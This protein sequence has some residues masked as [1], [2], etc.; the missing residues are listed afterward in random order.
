MSKARRLK[1][2]RKQE[3]TLA[4]FRASLLG[5]GDKLTD[6]LV[7]MIELQKATA[8]LACMDA[9]KFS[10]EPRTMSAIDP[11]RD[12]QVAFDPLLE[13]IQLGPGKLLV[14][15]DGRIVAEYRVLPPEPEET[16]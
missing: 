1:K 12:D 8:I 9:L 10:F 14:E 4:R 15:H 2:K 11:L 16:E 5:I 13:P 7:A 6:V 3:E